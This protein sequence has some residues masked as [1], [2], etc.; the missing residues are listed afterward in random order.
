MSSHKKGGGGRGGGNDKNLVTNSTDQRKNCPAKSKHQ[1]ACKI[2][3]IFSVDYIYLMSLFQRRKP[4]RENAEMQ[5]CKNRKYIIFVENR[6]TCNIPYINFSIEKINQ[7]DNMQVILVIP[8]NRL[9]LHGIIW[10]HM[11][12][13]MT[14]PLL[15]NIQNIS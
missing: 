15:R 2:N 6:K 1:E 5:K 4:R 12:R 8:Y 10:L 9:H 13:I 11:V 7:K 14:K 3:I